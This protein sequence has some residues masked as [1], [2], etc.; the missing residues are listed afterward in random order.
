MSTTIKFV[1][2]GLGWGVAEQFE[3]E[4]G[5]ERERLLWGGGGE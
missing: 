4:A 5:S 1:Q 2:K 3:V